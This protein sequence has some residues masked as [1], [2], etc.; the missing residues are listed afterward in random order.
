MPATVPTALFERAVFSKNLCA[1]DAPQSIWAH[2]YPLRYHPGMDEK[3]KPLW[4]KIVATVVALLPMLYV[5]SL[6]PA[7]WW[8]G[9]DLGRAG[10]VEFFYDPLFT[11]MVNCGAR[12]IDMLKW[13]GGLWSEDGYECIWFIWF[14]SS[15]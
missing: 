8:V 3:R 2:G 9:D 15:G 12:A 6:G 11:A 1:L 10:S 7:C 13:Y 4:P 5:A 14:H